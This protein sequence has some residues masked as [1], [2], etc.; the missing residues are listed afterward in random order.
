M[1]TDDRLAVA[2][3]VAR[4]AGEI[5]MAAFG[6]LVAGDVH[7][8]GTV[9]LLTRVD[10]ESEALIRR[11]LSAA[12]ADDGILGEEGGTSG[13]SNSRFVWV[14]DPIDGTTNYVHRSPH[15][16]V[17]IGLCD[18]SVDSTGL[19][20]VAGVIHAPAYGIGGTSWLGSDAGAYRC[21]HG[22]EQK[23]E[24]MQVSACGRLGDALIATGFPYDRADH[25]DALLA[26][27]GRALAKT[28]GVRR[29]GAASLDFAYVAEGIFDGF[30]EYRLAPWDMAAG[31]AIVRAAG[32][33]VT[34]G[35]G[36]RFRLDSSCVVAAGPGI[37]GALLTDVVAP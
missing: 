36:G 12:F 24:P 6:R 26:P 29:M 17:S 23:W 34:D 15:F 37:H 28:R 5:A 18:S 1:T 16:A 7:H 9:D 2:M 10:K 35:A 20:P 27:V 19:T 22:A 30:F 3:A 21:S 4:E 13:P 14:V 25:V 33:L 8:K 31:A 11:R 32:G